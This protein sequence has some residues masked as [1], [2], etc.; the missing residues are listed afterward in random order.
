MHLLY[1][2]SILLYSCIVFVPV[3]V[4]KERMQIQRPAAILQ[5]SVSVATDTSFTASGAANIHPVPGNLAAN[6]CSPTPYKSGLHAV[7]TILKEEGLLGIYRGY[8]I[9]MLSFGPFS[10]LYFVFY[11]EFKSM[12]LRYRLNSTRMHS[13][14]AAHPEEAQLGTQSTS[15]P[16]ES[17][18]AM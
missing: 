14:S 8:F 18:M 16:F 2:P 17:T 15:L 11:E 9:T 1:L 4:I 12:I 5:K 3:D 6:S 10:A 13:G 7:R